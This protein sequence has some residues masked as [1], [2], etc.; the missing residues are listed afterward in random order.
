MEVSSVA[1]YFLNVV[2]LQKLCYNVENETGK[3]KLTGI[4][5]KFSD[6][7]RFVLSSKGLF[8]VPGNLS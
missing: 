5:L 2:N 6:W 4:V 1:L 8:F 7:Q 3:Q